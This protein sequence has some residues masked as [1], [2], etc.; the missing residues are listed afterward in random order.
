M[1]G[2]AALARANC[3]ELA[4]I[5]RIGALKRLKRCAASQFAALDKGKVVPAV[6][7]L[8]ASMTDAQH[9]RAVPLQEGVQGCPVLPVSSRTLAHRLS[10]LMSW[11]PEMNAC[12]MDPMHEQVGQMILSYSSSLCP[13][14]AT[15]SVSC[16]FW[17]SWLKFLFGREG[18]AWSDN[19]IEDRSQ[20]EYSVAVSAARFSRHCLPLE[21]AFSSWVQ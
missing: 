21:R 10:L 16:L 12:G 9:Q 18:R 20:R 8:H 11:R 7:R 1:A 17:S 6:G 15:R 5:R 2:S 19:I 3:L 4:A 13:A 14:S